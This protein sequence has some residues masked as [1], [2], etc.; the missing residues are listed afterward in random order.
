M[1]MHMQHDFFLNCINNEIE[2][3]KM[4]ENF[5]QQALIHVIKTLISSIIK[6]REI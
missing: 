6:I 4:F 3:K 5:S 2:Q 1:S